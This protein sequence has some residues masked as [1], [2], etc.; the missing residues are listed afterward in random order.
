M[1]GVI[2]IA[3]ILIWALGNFPKNISYTRNYEKLIL[4][5][6]T[7]YDNLIRTSDTEQKSI[8][9][10]EKKEKINALL[11]DKKSE[12]QEGSFIGQLGHFLEPVIQPLGF[13]WKMGVSIFTGIAAKE[14]VV[15]TMGVLYQADDKSKKTSESLQEKLKSQRYKSGK[16]K[17]ELVFSPVV[18]LSFMVFILIYFPCVAVI[19]AVKKESGTWTWAAFTAIYTTG[20][21]WLVSFLV[22]QVG[23]LF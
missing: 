11:L 1:G 9:V 3:S 10:S 14:V 8:L 5:T 22:Y 19:A 12:H 21:A 17:G 23:S 15:S 2:L 6:E 18:A 7:K 16:R 13:D 20:L 4:E